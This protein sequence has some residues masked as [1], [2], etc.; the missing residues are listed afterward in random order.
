[1]LR[2]VLVGEEELTVLWATGAKINYIYIDTHT[3]THIH[4]NIYTYKTAK[5]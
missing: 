2:R 3:Y 4:V 5:E 1:M